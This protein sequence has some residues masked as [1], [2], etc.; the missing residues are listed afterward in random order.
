M[1]TNGPSRRPVWRVVLRCATHGGERALESGGIQEEKLRR[2]I[3][4]NASAIRW[5]THQWPLD[6]RGPWEGRDALRW[7]RAHV[8]PPGLGTY[9]PV[10]GMARLRN[11]LLT[12]KKPSIGTQSQETV[13]VRTSDPWGQMDH[14]GNR[15]RRV[16]SRGCNSW[17]RESFGE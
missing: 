1:G 9:S 7:I 11:G 12:S 13:L 14:L 15:V 5:V 16:V 10:R 2:I 6:V 4:S 3:V 17:R 8:P